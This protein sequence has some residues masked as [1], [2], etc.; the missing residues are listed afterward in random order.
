VQAEL[1]GTPA[2]E[3]RIRD[4]IEWRHIEL[5]APMPDGKR[6]VR[7]HAGRLAERQCQRLHDLA[8]NPVRD[9]DDYLY[10]I[11]AARRNFFR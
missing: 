11:M 2:K 3:L 9:F 7:A 5:G 6:K 10:S 4:N 8:F 1:R